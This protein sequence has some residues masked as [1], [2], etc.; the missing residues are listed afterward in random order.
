MKRIKDEENISLGNDN[1]KN[2]KKIKINYFLNISNDEWYLILQNLQIGEIVML[3]LTCKQLFNTITTI[4]QQYHPYFINYTQNIKENNLNWTIVKSLR[5]FRKIIV[6]NITIPQLSEF[7]NKNLK[8]LKQLKHFKIKNN[9]VIEDFN[10]LFSTK[11]DNTKLNIETIKI[12]L[13]NDDFDFTSFELSEIDF[14][15]YKKENLNFENKFGFYIENLTI[16]LNEAKYLSDLYKILSNFYFLK[17]LTITF[18][19]NEIIDLIKEI[20]V[21]IL[22]HVKK[23]KIKKIDFNECGTESY[24]KNLIDILQLTPNIEDV[25]FIN[26]T[27]IDG[28]FLNFLVKIC[29]KIKKLKIDYNEDS[30][31]LI[32]DN[33]LKKLLQKLPNLTFLHLGECYKLSGKIFTELGKFGKNLKYIKIKRGLD[34]VDPYPLIKEFKDI[35]IG[36]GTLPN[37]FVN[38]E[39]F[40]I[41]NFD[42]LKEKLI[43]TL[44]ENAPN[45]KKL[46]G[47]ILNPTKELKNIKNLQKVCVSTLHLENLF[48][49]KDL[50][51]LKIVIDEKKSITKKLF[52]ELPTIFPKLEYFGCE[53]EIKNKTVLLNILQDKTN[54]P[55]LTKLNLPNFTFQDIKSIISTRPCFL[56][57]KN[58]CNNNRKNLKQQFVK[59]NF[60][61]PIDFERCWLNLLE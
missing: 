24:Y 3:S 61:D 10:L 53:K 4:L 36:G 35:Y 5:T 20:N 33:N 19:F 30:Y 54:W 11:I 40:C 34:L 12:Q 2:N 9:Y 16:H 58:N 59:S 26:I 28:E 25:T 32:T 38:L 47:I 46:S 41:K 51:K 43:E 55:N 23:L 50:K 8:N 18:Y 42:T 44:F 6:N 56:E 29:P 7:I 21:P 48:H 14:N 22:Y 1:D 39:T 15:L 17:S 57:I 27:G 60:K 49:L 13:N 37:Y 45:L 31:N 52:D